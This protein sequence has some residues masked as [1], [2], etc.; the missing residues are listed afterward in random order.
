MAHP[1]A[2]LTVVLLIIIAV[3]SLVNLGLT[4]SKK[5]VIETTTYTTTRYVT[6]TTTITEPEFKVT[7]LDENRVR[8]EVGGKAGHNLTLIFGARILVD[9]LRLVDP[10][11]IERAREGCE[12]LI[13]EVKLI[14]EGGN[15]FYPSQ[16]F[17][18]LKTD[19]RN[20]PA[21]ILVREGYGQYREIP[22]PFFGA[23]VISPKDVGMFYLLFEAER[24][25]WYSHYDL[26]LVY[27][28]PLFNTVY[29]Y[30]P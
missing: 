8:V 14:N 28:Y 19:T 22:Y 21:S 6:C 26:V 27:Y 5:P 15:Y 2:S 18:F 30:S 1:K 16:W 17:W 23:P 7:K 3:A 4:L 20:I 12:F 9:E 10:P 25:V 24:D 13:V 29:T 11:R